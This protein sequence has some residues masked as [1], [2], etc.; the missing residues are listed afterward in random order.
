LFLGRKFRTS[1]RT[2]VDKCFKLLN[3]SK[4]RRWWM[5]PARILRP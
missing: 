3:H 1:I 2:L 4:R 5:N